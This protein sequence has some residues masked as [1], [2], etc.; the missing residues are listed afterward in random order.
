LE[1]ELL[2]EGAE[3]NVTERYELAGSMGIFVDGLLRYFEKTPA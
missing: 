2:A 3:P 1:A